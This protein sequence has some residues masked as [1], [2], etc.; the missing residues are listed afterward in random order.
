[1]ARTIAGRKYQLTI[2]NPEKLGM[3]HEVLRKTLNDL[4]SCIYWCMCDEIGEQ[5]TYHTH[6]YLLFKNPAE[7]SMIQ[8]RFYG[9][10]IELAKGSN[11]ENRN[12]IK[13]E[14]KWANDKKN[15]TSLPDTFE[16]SGELPSEKSRRQTQSEE[17]YQMI[18]YGASNAE[19]LDTYPTTINS[20]QHLDRARQTI[21]EEQNKDKWRELDVT[22]LYGATGTGKTRQVMEKYGYS[23]VYRVTDYAHP[24]DS[25]KGQ[26]VIIFEEFRSGLPI[27]DMLNYLD[28]YPV[29]LPCRYA[30]RIACYTIVYIISNISLDEQYVNIQAQQPETYEA[31]KRRINHIIAKSNDD[32]PDDLWGWTLV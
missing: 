17:I 6:I 2:N 13:K 24:F 14:G 1:M 21:L 10:H 29:E 27:A 4:M 5:G 28:G 7:F 26:N 23:N 9:A 8:T 19:I 22:Y 32:C 16:E 3:T 11:I 12:Y 20:L 18:K 25:Y 31:F 15:E 30:N